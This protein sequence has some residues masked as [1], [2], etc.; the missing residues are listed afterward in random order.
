MRID[1]TVTLKIDSKWLVKAIEK[2]VIINIQR[3]VR[4]DMYYISVDPGQKIPDQWARDGSIGAEGGPP[5]KF[6]L[7]PIE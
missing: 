2:A 4:V 1:N 7:I 6:V 3:G 5:K